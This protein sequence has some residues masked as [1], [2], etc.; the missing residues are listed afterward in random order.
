MS[1][2]RQIDQR[3]LID[4]SAICCG[5]LYRKLHSSLAAPS[6]MLGDYQRLLE[7]RCEF[8]A[9]P[10]LCCDFF[11]I[12]ERNHGNLIV[13]L[14]FLLF[15]T[16]MKTCSTCMIFVVATPSYTKEVTKNLTMLKVPQQQN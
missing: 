1:E 6:M 3:N 12:I 9:M 16:I 15:F 4:E 2:A 10:S 14:Q 7:D 13:Q 8:S 11:Y 5:Q